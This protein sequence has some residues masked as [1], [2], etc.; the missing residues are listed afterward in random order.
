MARTSHRLSLTTPATTAALPTVRSDLRR[1]LD[2]AEVDEP[3]AADVVLAVWEVCAN[4]VEHAVDPRSPT[5]VV[6]AAITSR[7]IRVRVRN[8][9]G[10]RAPVRRATRGLGLPLVRAMMDDVRIRTEIQGTEVRMVRSLATS[11]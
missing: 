8:S 1:W 6:D 9:G 2:D 7:S 4:A 11:T 10:W 3:I 5:L